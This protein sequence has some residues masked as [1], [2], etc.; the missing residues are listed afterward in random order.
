MVRHYGDPQN[1][2]PEK[3]HPL[4]ADDLFDDWTYELAKSYEKEL[5]PA[6]RP[7]WEKGMEKSTSPKD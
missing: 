4:W 5:K 7:V 2:T 6:P 3:S 1:Q